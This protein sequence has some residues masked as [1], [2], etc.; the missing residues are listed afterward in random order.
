MTLAAAATV[1]ASSTPAQ[2]AAFAHAPRYDIY[3]AIHRA[4]RLFMNDTLGRLG[5][6]D[7]GDPVAVAGTLDQL[8]RLLDF[9][10]GHLQHENEFVHAAIEA[11]C[12]GG[13]QRLGAD[14]LHHLEEIAALEAEAAMLR[15]APGGPQALRLY[16]K[17]A[18]FVADNF[19]HMH[20][21]ETVHNELLWAAYRDDEIEAIEQ[22]I[23]ASIDPAERAL[24]L[25]WMTPALPPAERA[26]WYAGMQR[27]MPAPAFAAVMDAARLMLDDAA[28][29]R[30]ARSLG[31]PAGPR[32]LS[33]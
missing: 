16:R 11:R 25:R 18:L 29:Q 4:L 24:V 13:S 3:A 5:Q 21:E 2:S 15:A 17:L 30:L 26:A 32:A 22:R 10:R 28:W 33:R 12:P 8:A 6:I 31:V 27:S 7:C 14:H 23:V 1:P 19:Q 20:E 9:C